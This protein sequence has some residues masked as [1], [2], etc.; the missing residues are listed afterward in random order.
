MKAVTDDR[1]PPVALARR[2]WLG[3]GVAALA[4]H[5][6]AGAGEHDHHR[7]HAAPAEP[8]RVEAQYRV[9]AVAMID[10][11]ER[12]STLPAVL[13]DGRPVLLNFMFTSCQA[14]C[15]ITTRIF[16]DVQAQLG[17]DAGGAHMVSISIDPE[18]DTPA[19]LAAYAREHQAGP[20]W[21]F[22]TG[23]LAASIAVQR[24]FDA[25]RGDKMNHA[26]ATFLRAA[27]GTRWLRLEGF[28]PPGAI[29]AALRSWTG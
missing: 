10:H 5:G 18:Y 13:Q 7:H 19:R 14:V 6:T 3:L 16:A 25:Y 21:D 28:A 9:P 12:A 1:L 20:Q 26:P 15:P 4:V 22:L 8:R 23:T 27:S 11:R 2:R 29:V 24:A 17:A